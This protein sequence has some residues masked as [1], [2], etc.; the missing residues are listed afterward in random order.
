M[1]SRSN[2]N[3]FVYDG[4][5]SMVRHKSTQNTV[6]YEKGTLDD[7]FSLIEDD[8]GNNTGVK[9]PTVAKHPLN[10]PSSPLFETLRTMRTVFPNTF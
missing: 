7:D 2:P 10:S 1:P 8:R 6:Y 3:R 4:D 5:N 9:A